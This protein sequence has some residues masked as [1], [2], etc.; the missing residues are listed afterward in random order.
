MYII[1]IALTLAAAYAILSKAYKKGWYKKLKISL[2]FSS[3]NIFEGERGEVIETFANNKLLP[4]FWGSIQFRTPYLIRFDGTNIDHDYYK[5]DTVSAF[6][7]EEVKKRLPFTAQRRGYYKLIDC[8]VVAGDLL[9]DYK[10]ILQLKC[11]SE[12][13]VYPRTVDANRISIDFNKIIGEAV[14]RRSLF[15]DPFF[16]RG[17]RDYTQTD[18]MKKINWN[19]T[20]R[21]GNLKV[22]QYYSTQSQK[23]MLL[24]DFDGY[25][26]S[27]GQE[28]KE[29]IIRI[30]ATIAQKLTRSGISTGLMTNAADIISGGKIKTDCKSGQNHFVYLLR[31]LAK[32]NTD[33]LLMPFDKILDYL[34]K[35]EKVQ[36]ILISYFSGETLAKKVSL[37]ES[38]GVSIQWILLKDK[39][40]KTDF[41]KRR[42]M[43]VCEVN[44]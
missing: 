4:I 25:G 41:V 42:N 18:S 36:Y 3:G 1:L 6:S 19:A 22:N 28:I 8:S 15:E 12:L 5:N 2:E 9:F 33:S 13:Y 37:L 14:A 39:S 24:L 30:A 29:D 35:D 11:F 17:I 20:A 38:S 21:T 43:H 34:K 40:R 7:Y 10:M 16:F 26:K 27:D 31:E 32:I 23:V 44:Y